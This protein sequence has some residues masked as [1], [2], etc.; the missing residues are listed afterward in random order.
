MANFQHFFNPIEMLC[1][2]L[3]KFN[4]KNKIL[5]GFEKKFKSKKFKITKKKFKAKLVNNFQ[6]TEPIF[7][8]ITKNV[9]GKIPR[10]SDYLTATL[11]FSLG[12]K[13]VLHLQL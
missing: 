2:K 10:A 1:K 11:H 3:K 4:R 6:D 12:S 13:I 5:V 7:W 8:K 9:F